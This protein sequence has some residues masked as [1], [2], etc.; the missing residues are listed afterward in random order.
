MSVSRWALTW[1]H[2][3]VNILRTAHQKWQYGFNCNLEARKK[4]F[5]ITAWTHKVGKL[6]MRWSYWSSERGPSNSDG[7]PG[8]SV[9][10]ARGQVQ[11]SHV[12]NTI[13]AVLTH[14]LKQKCV[15]HANLERELREYCGHLIAWYSGIHWRQFEHTSGENKE[16]AYYS[17]T[18]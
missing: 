3:T 16:K 8:L 5:L 2:L 15:K 7:F 4:K 9:A 18:Y 12:S 13:K 1:C 11:M 14:W 10:M 6:S 17:Y